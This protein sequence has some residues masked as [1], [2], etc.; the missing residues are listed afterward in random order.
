MNIIRPKILYPLFSDLT[1]VNGVGP[2]TA[3]LIEKKIGKNL[4]DLLFHLPHSVIRRLN[5]LQLKNCPSQSIITKS[6]KIKKH[7]P[8]YYQSR[9]PYI[10]FGECEGFDVEIIFFHFRSEYLKDKFPELTE[11]MVSGKIEWKKDKVQITHPDYLVNIND[12]DK[13][14]K[15]E[16]VYP[17]TSGI[18]N[19]IIRKSIE[20]SLNK[21]PNNFPEWIPKKLIDEKKWL[22]FK[23]SLEFIHVPQN[24]KEMKLRNLCFERLG[25]DEVYANQLGLSLY[26]KKNQKIKLK[27]EKIEYFFFTSILKKLDFQLTNAQVKCIN[28]IENDITKKSQMK[29]L[30]Q[31]DVGSGKTLVALSAILNLIEINKQA[32]LMAPTDLLCFQHFEF[33]SKYTSHLKIK[34]SLLTSKIKQV[35]KKKIIKDILDGNSQIIIGTHSLISDAVKFYNLGI[36]VID[37]QHKFGVNQRNKILSKGENIHLLLLTATP[38]PRS[39]TMTNYG[40]LDL[41]II[42]ETPKNRQS[43]ITKVIPLE[44]Y[45]EVI[46]AIKRALRRNEKVYWICPLLEMSEKLDM[47][48]LVKRYEELLKEFK[49][50]SPVMAH[51][52]MTKEER[53]NSINSFFTNKSKILVASTVIE[54]GIDIPD[55]TII[56]I[57]N[58]ERFGLAQLHQLRG[59]VGRGSLQSYCILMYNKTIS[60]IGKSRLHTIRNSNDGFYIAEKDLDLRGPGEIFGS[61]QSGEENFRLFTLKDFELLET[62]KKLSENNSLNSKVPYSQQILM[63]IFNNDEY[64]QN[65]N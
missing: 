51:G 34:V 48:A 11:M 10:I 31:G 14:P 29:R 38:I 49:E 43:I 26:R 36:A 21:I 61:K 5:N 33:I 17:L 52:K 55:A 63:S 6:V 35:D 19:K 3:K 53:E 57:E 1:T 22:S 16:T 50:Y 47:V 9:K 62:A 2:K 65:L 59:R 54:V 24:E 28:E 45:N 12:K 39:L 46:T 60:E 56:I 32:V 40:D 27:N 4:I 25:F 15:F 37:E 7:I 41:S 8:G 23:K 58:S 30:L 44:R 64:I 18:T 13:I 42:N 20:S